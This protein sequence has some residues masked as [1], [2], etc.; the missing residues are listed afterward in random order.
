MKKSYA[1]VV[2]LATVF[3]FFTACGNNSD[4][5]SDDLAGAITDA[6]SDVTSEV[7]LVADDDSSNIDAPSSEIQES[8]SVPEFDMTAFGDIEITGEYFVPTSSQPDLMQS[9]KDVRY[10]Y[11]NEM[12][13]AAYKFD[14][15]NPYQSAVEFFDPSNGESLYWQQF[16]YPIVLDGMRYEMNT[17]SVSLWTEDRFMHYYNF[18]GANI[19]TSSFELP[20]YLKNV[21][22][23]NPFYSYDGLPFAE[24]NAW[25][26]ATFEDG[27]ALIPQEGNPSEDI[28][29]PSMW[30][31]FN[32]GFS[33]D[34]P[35]EFRVAFF[36]DVQIIDEG[37]FVVC[38]IAVPGSQ[39]THV[40]LYTLNTQTLEEQFHFEIFMGM[41]AD[42]HITDDNT[43][44]VTGYDSGTKINIRE[45]TA[46]FFSVP[47]ENNRATYN[48]EDF[49]IASLS[50]SGKIFHAGDINSPIATTS[51]ENTH[52]HQAI[53]NYLVLVNHSDD[54][55]IKT[56]L[57]KVA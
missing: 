35:E 43:I 53:E 7:G 51:N 8:S 55:G 6:L 4:D 37:R 47:E 28:F 46:E 25:W 48:Y 20:S 18:D 12:I 19:N 42:Y 45:G 11:Y 34:T 17:D 13:V 57:I 3:V 33:D 15:E 24:E 52:I 21:D 26:G 1:W 2:I 56:V 32:V 9:L 49:F 29:I 30:L 31:I 23:T 10:I 22:T 44:M 16:E 38:A 50:D 27:L 36:D 5:N 39:T 54:Y 41:H 40:G 14:S